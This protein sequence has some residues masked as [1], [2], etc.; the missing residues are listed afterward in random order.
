MQTTRRRLL[1]M[2]LALPAGA[3]ALTAGAPAWAA[4]TEDDHGYVRRMWPVPTTEADWAPVAQALGRP[5]KL[6]DDGRVYRTSFPRRDLTVISHG[7]TVR[8]ALS[9][10]SY[11]AFS[12]YRDGRVLVMGDLVVTEAELPVV[13]DLVQ[14]AGLEQTAIH[15]HLLA[16]EPQLWW[17]HVH[18]LGDAVGAA[19][20]VRAAL[21]DTGT[22]A[23]LPPDTTPGDLDAAALDRTLG[24][25]GVW[26]GGI[27]RFTIARHE[28]IT[29]HDRVLAPGMGPTTVLGFQPTGGGGAAVNGDIAMRAGEVQ[30]VIRA[31]RGGGIGVVE[32]HHHMLRDRPH[33]FYL[34]FWAHADAV[35]L[36]GTLR[37]AVDAT[38]TAAP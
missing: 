14:G 2:G 31:L 3:G 26:D 33:L 1:Q 30:A 5:G 10:S 28:I 9:L 38:H 23:A 20:A 12:R 25:S 34:H 22:P 24:R 8:P 19:R 6:L 4:G 27:Y 7:V 37:D 17:T 13:T 35:E 32:L 18:A 36:A 15:K 21:D 29:D 11:A 16:H